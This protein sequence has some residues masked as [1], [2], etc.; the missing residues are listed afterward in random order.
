MQKRLDNGSRRQEEQFP[1]QNE[2]VARTGDFSQ[3]AP[4]VSQGGAPATGGRKI[5]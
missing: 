3:T 5:H 4:R 2:L 1:A